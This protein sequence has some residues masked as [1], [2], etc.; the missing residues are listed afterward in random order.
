METNHPLPR[1][2]NTGRYAVRGL[3]MLCTCGHTLGLHTA[4]RSKGSQP[5]LA[6]CDCDCGCFK[7]AKR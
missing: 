2:T 7:K 5:C 3:D 6:E 1:E 4:A